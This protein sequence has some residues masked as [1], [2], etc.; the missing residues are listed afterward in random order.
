MPLSE[1][2]QRI[3]QE[4]EARL[5]ETDPGLAREVSS[6][7]IYSHAL[8][9]IRWAL[10][11][12]VTG[13]VIMVASL[14]AHWLI[15]FVGFLLMLG[16]ALAVERNGRRMG[17]AG[18]AQLTGNTNGEGSSGVRGIFGTA[19]QRMRERFQRNTSDEG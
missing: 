13:M 19:G 2:E 10:F 5:Y 9:N 11:G 14:S 12:F 8:R 17:R 7:T 16:S 15:A 3:L 18:W 1:H 6:T 4:I